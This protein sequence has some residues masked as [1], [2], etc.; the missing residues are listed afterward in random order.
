MGDTIFTDSVNDTIIKTFNMICDRLSNCEV[1]LEK[2]NNHLIHKELLVKSG[3]LDNKLLN[4][5][6]EIDVCNPDNLDVDILS[7]S[8]IDITLNNCNC[9][10]SKKY[11]EDMIKDVF[12]DFEHLHPEVFDSDNDEIPECSELGIISLYK[13]I[14]DEIIYKYTLKKFKEHEKDTESRRE[15]YFFTNDFGLF[16]REFNI[17]LNLDD[18]YIKYI[19]TIIKFVNILGHKDE[20]IKCISITPI[21][22]VC[23]V[24]YKEFYLIKNSLNLLTPDEL[25]KHKKSIH[26]L[27]KYNRELLQNK[28][29]MEIKQ[30]Q[31]LTNELF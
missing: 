23:F 22:Y 10:I 16:E 8:D 4:Y 30:L 24:F 20:C 26:Y 7:C 27:M 6:F 13:Y 19:N 11:Y 25:N 15:P 18:N 28:M 29:S 21:Y 12:P 9:D 5:N 31:K 2:M 14:E 17:S 3:P 1:F